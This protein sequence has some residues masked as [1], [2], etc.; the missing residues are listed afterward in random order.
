ME[1]KHTMNRLQLTLK[2][3]KVFITPFVYTDAQAQRRMSSFK[4]MM[5][6]G[7]VLKLIPVEKYPPGA[8]YNYNRV[9]LSTIKYLER[10][11][12]VMEN[13]NRKDA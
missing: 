5:K 7:D 13:D 6:K 9:N 4:W 11:W 10:Q 3:G 1:G 12:E 2:N 8:E